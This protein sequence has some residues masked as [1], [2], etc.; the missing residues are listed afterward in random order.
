MTVLV[1]DDQPHVVAGILFGV[2][3]KKLGVEQV[4]KAYSAFEAREILRKNPVNILL[5]D[6]EMPVENGLS[7]LKW[8]RDEGYPVE[9][10]FLTS[11]ANFSYAQEAIRCGGFDYLLQPARYEKI[12][13]A[14]ASAIERIEQQEKDRK[15]SSYGQ[16]LYHKRDSIL[17]SLLHDWLTGKQEDTG[18]L[19]HDL[20]QLG[21]SLKAST[22]MLPVGIEFRSCGGLGGDNRI[23][24]LGSMLAELL[25]GGGCH[26]LLAPLEDDRF[27]LL[28]WRDTGK[29]GSPGESARL[30][31]ALSRRMEQELNCR[32][33]C[34]PSGE[35]VPLRE[36][37]QTLPALFRTPES[38]FTQQDDLMTEVERL[39]AGSG[40]SGGCPWGELIDLES[41][42]PLLLCAKIK[43]CLLELPESQRRDPDYLKRFFLDF[44]QSLSSMA[45]GQGISINDI[46]EDR[47]MLET[48]LT[49]YSS[50]QELERLIDYAIRYF[51]NTD[52]SEKREQKQMDVIVE[53]IRNNIEQDIRRADIAEAVYLNP[54]Y[55]SRLFKKQ[56]NLP[57]KEF[58][59]QEKMKLARSLLQT[60]GLPIS[61]IAMKV[62]YQNFSHFSQTY[63]RVM[64]LSPT[65]ERETGGTGA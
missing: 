5:C 59:I 27:L 60:T 12:E 16:L 17:R 36:V 42:S 26:W 22:S 58:I 54:N 8:A 14:V 39:A 1:I 50:P 64:G 31:N 4:F 30:T 24:L 33:D 49:S 52:V 29:P 43:N 62:G 25:S 6:I 32:V 53:Y 3:W 46:F 65:Q 28:L 9:C 7:L 15:F 51:E 19:L 38:L 48:A 61:V 63:R 23:I 57:L 45:K 35:S 44:L 56:M 34:F 18:A 55:V 47:R 2:D 13:Q 37:P 10:I 11:H 41:D 40:L 20:E 21:V